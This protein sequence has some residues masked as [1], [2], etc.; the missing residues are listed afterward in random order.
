M[1]RLEIGIFEL[2]SGYSTG[3]R[4]SG[5]AAQKRRVVRGSRFKLSGLAQFSYTTLKKF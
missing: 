1:I 4:P 2:M 3:H 5:A